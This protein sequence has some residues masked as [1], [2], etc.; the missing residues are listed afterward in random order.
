MKKITLFFATLAL[1]CAC[2][3]DIAFTAENNESSE[4][5]SH[6]VSNAF[7]VELIESVT[8]DTLFFSEPYQ[9]FGNSFQ[10]YNIIKEHREHKD[11]RVN[12]GVLLV[13]YQDEEELPLG[14][15]LWIEK[16]KYS[17]VYP[18][19]CKKLFIKPDVQID[20]N[21]VALSEGRNEE[22]V[23]LLADMACEN[24]EEAHFNQNSDR[25]LKVSLDNNRDVKVNNELVGKV[26]YRFETE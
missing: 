22:V 6:S 23:F 15:E 13:G 17:T 24:V 2:S 25:I 19:I 14:L 8:I 3:N 20:E 9:K 1:T 7:E 16:T 12:L 21:T 10:Y 26:F 18:N 4:K 11:G 5:D